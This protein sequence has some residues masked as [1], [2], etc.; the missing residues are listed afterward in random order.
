MAEQVGTDGWIGRC[1]RQDS[2]EPPSWG[3]ILNSRSGSSKREAAQLCGEP[4]GQVPIRPSLDQ[5]ATPTAQ[6][7]LA[8]LTLRL[9]RIRF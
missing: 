9:Q 1:G 2:A 3:G 7:N 4:S 8:V 6:Q 5:A